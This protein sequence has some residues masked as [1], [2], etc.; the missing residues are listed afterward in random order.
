MKVGFVKYLN[1]LPF[2]THLERENCVFDHPRTLS[3]QL[4]TGTLDIALTSS[5][6]AFKH[7]LQ[8]LPDFGIGCRGPILSV[9]LYV[10]EDLSTL[11]N[12]TIALS[13]H[14]NT[15]NALLKVLCHHFWNVTPQFT[16]GTEKKEAFVLIGDDALQALAVPGYRVL[17]LGQ[18]WQEA[19][20]LPFVFALFA[21]KT[22][23]FSRLEE[24][25]HASLE[26]FE[27][28]SATFVKQ[29]NSSLPLDLL[30]KYY[31][32][33]VYRLGPKEKEGL[34]LFQTLYKEIPDVH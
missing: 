25:L 9:N 15:S 29:V 3:E 18:C 22:G 5:L 14:S 6:T 21:Y 27:N 19:T 33:C 32:L 17:D 4:L 20:S 10:R 2:L 16:E 12:A 30:Q 28:N 26:W 23:L 7:H 34:Q 24:R 13:P 11:H 31:S 8:T 1:A